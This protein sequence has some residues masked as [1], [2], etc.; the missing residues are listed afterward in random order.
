M[1]DS[2]IEHSEEFPSV[3]FR[4]RRWQRFERDLD[5]WLQTPEGR[6]TAW[7]A[8]QAVAADPAPAAGS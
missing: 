8:A 3:G 1:H 2:T 6:F 5:D 7:C 4:A